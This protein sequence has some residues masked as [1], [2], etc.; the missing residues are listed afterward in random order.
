[1]TILYLLAALLQTYTYNV[2]PL[3][4]VDNIPNSIV[5]P[6][7]SQEAVISVIKNPLKICSLV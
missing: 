6:D 1:M 3:L 7:I 4:Y 5:I 2:N